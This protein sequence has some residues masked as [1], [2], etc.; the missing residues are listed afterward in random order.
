MDESHL[1]IQLVN[2]YDG[3]KPEFNNIK[4][5]AVVRISIS[6]AFSETFLEWLSSLCSF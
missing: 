4:V 5:T 1:N 6:F 2:I 3:S